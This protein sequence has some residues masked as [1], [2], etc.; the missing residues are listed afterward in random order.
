[1][2]TPVPITQ[3]PAVVAMPVTQV[4]AA[5][6]RIASPAVVR[7]GSFQM[8]SVKPHWWQ[9]AGASI[10]GF[11]G[12]TKAAV[13]AE[14]LPNMEVVTPEPLRF[15]LAEGLMGHSWGVWGA[16]S[17][18]VVSGLLANRALVA[19]I[20]ALERQRTDFSKP[21][22]LASGL[23]WVRRLMWGAA[24]MS[25][26][27]IF[28]VDMSNLIMGSG[29]I[30]AILALSAKDTASNMLS[31]WRI[32]N[33]T[34]IREGDRIAVKGVSGIIKRI[35]WNYVTLES[36]G[37]DSTLRNYYIPTSTVLSE[38]VE[39]VFLDEAALEKLKIGDWISISNGIGGQ[40]ECITDHTI[41]IKRENS[42]GVVEVVHIPLH[43]VTEH[44]LAY[45][46]SEPPP[47]PEGL[48]KGSM[49]ELD[50][51]RGKILDY[52]AQYLRLQTEDG[53]YR[54]SRAKF[55][56]SWAVLDVPDQVEAGS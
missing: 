42:S 15:D 21:S 52:N 40:M 41:G 10:A 49:V 36:R 7:A 8:A 19:G 56:N 6:G 50:G 5:A 46:G 16:A 23:R 37:E 55:Q 45:H 39:E 25:E 48:V 32:R 13:A 26:L 22:Y 53:V 24:F 3:L 20:D 30:A 33:R 31:F 2:N 47:L 17:A 54:I 1:M 35:G 44:S 34:E 51:K 18:I 29:I 43:K 28:N 12:A 11:F 14:K 38:P 27:K 9:R 4:V